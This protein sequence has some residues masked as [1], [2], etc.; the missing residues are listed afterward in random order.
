MTDR[1]FDFI[2][3]GFANG[4]VHMT[5]GLGN[6]LGVALAGLLLTLAFQYFSGIPGAALDIANKPA[7]S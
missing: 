4:M 2:V 6:V 3:P 5:F 7:T 1:P